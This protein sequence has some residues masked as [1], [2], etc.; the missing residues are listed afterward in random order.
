MRKTDKRALLSNKKD[1]SMEWSETF[2]KKGYDYSTGYVPTGGYLIEKQLED[3][4]NKKSSGFICNGNYFS[5]KSPKE[6]S[7]DEIDYISSVVYDADSSIHGDVNNRMERIDMKSFLLRYMLELIS[8]NADMGSRV[9]TSIRNLK[10]ISYMQAPI[11]IMME[12][13]GHGQILQIQL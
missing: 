1:E 6:P 12:P 10:K 13:L 4:Y 2:E 5:V 8:L 7:L 9:T 3:Y 11:R